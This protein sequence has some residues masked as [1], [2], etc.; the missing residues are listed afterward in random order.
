MNDYDIMILSVRESD[1]LTFSR[2]FRIWHAQSRL[3]FTFRIWHVQTRLRFNRHFAAGGAG[4][5]GVAE[6][7]T[8]WYLLFA[9][10]SD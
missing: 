6:I 4:K 7:A 9:Y 2:T 8:V 3:R 5:C 1:E 10:T